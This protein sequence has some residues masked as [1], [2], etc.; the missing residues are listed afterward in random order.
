MH[1]KDFEHLKDYDNVLITDEK[2]TIIFYDF[3]DLKVLKENNLQGSSPHKHCGDDIT[4][5][6]KILC[7][8]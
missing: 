2:G 8:S 4:N 1:L 7:A 6:G 3:A 5:I